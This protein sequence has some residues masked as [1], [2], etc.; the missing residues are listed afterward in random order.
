MMKRLC[1]GVLIITVLMTMG[2]SSAIGIDAVK[3]AEYEAGYAAGYAAGV[4]KVSEAAATPAP[5]ATQKPLT[6]KKP[7]TPSSVGSF[8]N[9]FGT[10]KTKCAHSG[11]N[12]YIAKSGDTNC[13]TTHSRRCIDC[14]CY[15]DEDAMWCI[16]CIEKALG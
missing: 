4:E 1:F 15:I 11:C 10:A 14:N 12:N 5:T 8:T 16:A 3:K 2:C 13:C 7:S 9:K 6:T